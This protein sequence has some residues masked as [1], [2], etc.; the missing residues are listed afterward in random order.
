[1]SECFK[2]EAKWVCCGGNDQ[3]GHQCLSGLN[4]CYLQCPKCNK[5]FRLCGIY[6]T[7]SDYLEKEKEKNINLNNR[8]KKL[9]KEISEIKE[10]KE[11]IQTEFI[12]N[13]IIMENKFK[14]LEN[15]IKIKN[16]KKEDINYYLEMKDKEI[17]NLKIQYEKD[18]KIK[19]LEYKIQ[20]N[21]IKNEYENKLKM[22]QRNLEKEVDELK[23]GIQT[24]DLN[25]KLP[26]NNSNLEDREIEIRCY[27]NDDS[28]FYYNTKIHLSEKFSFFI[29]SLIT[30]YSL[31]INDYKFK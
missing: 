1:M 10:E 13:K 5:T 11:K 6:D 9:E 3:Y 7:L 8:I 29:D 31:N 30:K 15:N 22:N 2:I 12:S 14:E 24:L 4:H 16:E 23:K 20:L 19:E 25:N 26:K 18:L 28:K 17:Q 21:D 27:S